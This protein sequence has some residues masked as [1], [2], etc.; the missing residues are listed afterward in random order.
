MKKEKQVRK[1]FS[2]EELKEIE[3]IAK[4]HRMAGKSD[5]EAQKLAEEE[6]RAFDE[7]ADEAYM[8]FIRKMQLGDV[9][10]DMFRRYMNRYKELAKTKGT[11]FD[12]RL[13]LVKVKDRNI[14]GKI[15]GVVLKFDVLIK[16][17][18]IAVSSKQMEFHNDKEMKDTK[19]WKFLM[20]DSLLLDMMF[21]GLAFLI[22]E[23]N[24]K[25]GEPTTAPTD[26]TNTPEE[27]VLAEVQ[28]DPGQ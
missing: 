15:R 11:E 25:R 24:A 6:V 23:T 28:P 22:I 17:E 21:R 3:S 12:Y 19:Y 18:W 1:T 14:P 16:G 9:F 13:E 20:Y 2:E 4:E 10:D 8:N 7:K 27:K 26:N 5:E